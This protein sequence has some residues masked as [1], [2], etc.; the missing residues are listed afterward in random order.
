MSVD[1]NVL[2]S[3]LDSFKH[4]YSR[5]LA[6]PPSLQEY[7]GLCLAEYAGS[8]VKVPSPP[9]L[10]ATSSEVAMTSGE[11]TND[12]LLDPDLRDI[13]IEEFT[14]TDFFGDEVLVEIWECPTGRRYHRTYVRNN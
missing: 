3:I 4:Q 1:V 14:D 8:L 13:L 11:P 12:L 5:L 2:K 6:L 10:V 9:G 7:A